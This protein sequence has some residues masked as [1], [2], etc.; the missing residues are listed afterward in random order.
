M[1]PRTAR[2]TTAPKPSATADGFD[3]DSLDLASA[4]EG[5]ATMQL[6]HPVSA[7]PI[8]ITFEVLGSDAPTYRKNIRKLRDMLAKAGE[9]DEEEDPER[10]DLLSSAR[11]AACAVRGWSGVVWQ[12]EPLP[13]SF[14]NAVMVFSA[15]PWV[16]E[17]VE[18]FRNRRANFFKV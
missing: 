10:R 17:Q 5:G 3:L 4:A 13:Y 8:G 12:G 7:E 15:R 1:A 2:T 18:F 11:V 14:D 16:A 9:D 6:L